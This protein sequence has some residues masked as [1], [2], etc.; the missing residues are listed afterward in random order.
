MC[1]LAGQDCFFFLFSL[2]LRKLL[3]KSDR[4]FFDLGIFLRKLDGADKILE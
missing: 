2:K 1:M 4:F 3:E